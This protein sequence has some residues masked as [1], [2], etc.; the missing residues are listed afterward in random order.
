MEGT[1]EITV[2]LN[3][4]HVRFDLPIS[5]TGLIESFLNLLSGYVDKGVR[6]NLT[7]VSHVSSLLDT[8]PSPSKTHMTSERI[9]KKTQ[10]LEWREEIKEL[11]SLQKR[12]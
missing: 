7:T 5:D 10:M 11:I 6:L 2:S 12:K 1:K 9:V 8:I 4:K 3:E